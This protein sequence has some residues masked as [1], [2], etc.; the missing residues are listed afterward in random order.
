[1]DVHM[2]KGILRQQGEPHFRDEG[3]S[4]FGLAEAAT[5]SIQELFAGLQADLVAFHTGCGGKNAVGDGKAEDLFLGLHQ[6]GYG[7][8]GIGV[9]AQVGEQVVKDPSQMAQIHIKAALQF[10]RPGKLNVETLL[11]QFFL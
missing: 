5:H 10:F 4:G 6:N 9:F 11:G 3:V 8:G 7:V 2:G 1:M